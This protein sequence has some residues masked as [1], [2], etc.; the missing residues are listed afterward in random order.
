MR[1]Y[2]YFLIIFFILSALS[3]HKLVK[4]IKPDDTVI[5]EIIKR[6][7]EIISFSDH[8]TRIEVIIDD[9]FEAFLR[10]IGS[11]YEVINTSEDIRRELEG[12]HSYNEMLTEIQNIADNHPEY[13]YL[14]S[15]GP[16][17]CNT[18]FQ[19]GY[20]DYSEYQ[21]QIW[22]IKL[23]DNPSV[24][25]N[26]PNIYFGGLIHA[27]ETISLEVT[28]YIL[29]YL[30]DNYGTNPEVTEWINNTQIWF[31]P[32]INPDGYKMVYDGIYSY[33]R[34]N[35]RDN[36]FNHIP[37]YSADGVDLNRNFGYV[38]GSN[39]TSS[40]PAASNYNGPAPWSEIEINYLRD[41]LRSRKFAGGITYH[42][43]AEKVLYPLGNLP[44]VCSYDHEVMH[45][46]AAE[47]AQTIPQM[48]GT[49]YYVP[50]QAVDFGYTCQGTMGDWGYAE[51]R[52]FSFT[53]ELATSF[54]PPS[55]QV[56]DICQDNLQAALIFLNRVH[57]AT[58]TGQVTDINGTPLQAEIVVTGLDDNPEMTPVEPYRSNGLF[59]RFDRMLLPGSYDVVFSKEGYI[60]Q[61]F[62]NI[63]INE[64]QNTL[65]DVTLSYNNELPPLSWSVDITA[66]HG[67]FSDICILG[68]AENATEDYD[69]CFDLVK[70]P[71][72]P[73]EYVSIFFPHEEWHHPLNDNFRTD[74]R[75]YIDLEDQQQIWTM[76]IIADQPGTIDVGFS[77]SNVPNQIIIVEDVQTGNQFGIV[78]NDVLS[79]DYFEGEYTFFV[80]AGP[81][82][83]MT[84]ELLSPIEPVILESGTTMQL[85]WQL[86][87]PEIVN[88]TTLYW[89]NNETSETTEII[90]LTDETSFEWVIPNL[91]NINDIKLLIEVTDDFG[92][93]STLESSF[94]I[95]IGGNPLTRELSAG[96]HLWGIPLYLTSCQTDS[97]LYDLIPPFYSFGYNEGGYFINDEIT[98]GNAYW[99]GLT[100]SAVISV[101]GEFIYPDYPFHLNSG[102]NL[103][104]NPFILSV[105]K[106]N[107]VFSDGTSSKYW[108]EAVS[109]GWIADV[110][111]C[112]YENSYS[113]TDD[114]APWNG[115]WLGTT[116]ELDVV[117]QVSSS[118][119]VNN[120]RND[121]QI[122]FSAISTSGFTDNMT[123]LGCNQSASDSYDFNDIPEPP[124]PP[125][126]DFRL[127]FIHNDWNYILG[128]S[129]ASDIKAEIISN[130]IKIWYLTGNSN[131][132]VLLNWNLSQFPDDLNLLLVTDYHYYNLRD[133]NDITLSAE[134]FQSFQIWVSFQEITPSDSN[135]TPLNALYQNY[136][137]PASVSNKKNPLTTITFSLSQE[138]SVKLEIYNLKGQLVNT[139]INKN[140]RQ[141]YHDVIWTGLNSDGNAVST[142]LYLYRLKTDT[143]NSVKKMLI[144]K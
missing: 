117:F 45:D 57:H 54:S 98:T 62:E 109:S 43:A 34:K 69:V 40:N 139:L 95:V 90:E 119:V 123:I 116:R 11:Y 21:H 50:Q 15:L 118:P 10:Q 128:N 85:E 49:G 124:L 105:S 29:N 87:H 89:V 125:L 75:N 136:P 71:L 52:M 130:E 67:N 48:D 104:S 133:F 61:S 30:T 42:S 51:E 92:N 99:L 64:N 41:L 27:R 76:K 13:A 19:Q 5:Y 58:L 28:L 135:N 108:H 142:G 106:D 22:C 121:W 140:M 46:L 126:T 4:I 73:S 134:E 33:Q 20:S 55:A 115:Y 59:G 16:S 72:P 120:H 56:S 3:A 107:L 81:T 9:E 102:W 12:Y 63:V 31:I 131:T 44:D 114:I 100:D 74:I 129:F 17:T 80:Y 60:S 143:F 97:V 78:D 79:I 53:I 7:Y 84:I 35:L 38:W 110:M 113:S 66:T 144:L 127:S 132:N 82:S 47:M 25:E 23:S 83:P 96:W 6:Q 1:K 93:L 18:Y 14:F 68:T 26:E 103:V 86:N 8:Y 141:G 65:L 32:M 39:G 112:W 94:P 138:E 37:D 88:Q 137:N 91:C 2:F 70:P 24:E 111:Y 122:T 36:N 101:A 77:L